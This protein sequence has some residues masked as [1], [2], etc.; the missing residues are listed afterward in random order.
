[1]NKRENTAFY[2]FDQFFLKKHGLGIFNYGFL[3]VVQN[4]A[5]LGCIIGLIARS[6]QAG[7]ELTGLNTYLVSEHVLV[8]SAVTYFISYI[9]GFY[10][11]FWLANRFSIN[12]NLNLNQVYNYAAIQSNSA[13]P[14]STVIKD[15]TYEFARFGT[16]LILPV[17]DLFKHIV[18][19]V[20]VVIFL[21]ISFP[22]IIFPV[23]AM[24]VPYVL[25]WLLSKNYF[26]RTS[27]LISDCLADR[28]RFADKQYS[29]INLKTEHGKNN[30]TVTPY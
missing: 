26:Q 25:F 21:A 20:S 16:N 24:G 7:S 3:T 2:L 8:L 29:D 28:Q 14:V 27:V 19:L 15:V 13:I 10:L 23:L 12:L 9:S 6:D 22:N 11:Q 18:T 17:L 1:M 5:F 30:N 4:L